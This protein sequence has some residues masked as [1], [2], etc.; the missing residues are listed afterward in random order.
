M[1]IVLNP[2]KPALCREAGDFHVLARMQSVPDSGVRRTP[3]NLVVVIDR[4]GS[5]QGEKLREA[6]RC[7]LDL[8]DRMADTD[9]IGL[10]QYDDEVD[11]LL[12]LQPVGDVRGRLAVAVQSIKS[13]GSTNLHGGWLK[14]GELLAP[15]AGREAVCHVIL[16]SDGQANHGVVDPTAICE[17]VAELAA[18]GI[19]TTTVGVGIDFNESLMTAMARAG[20]GRAHYGERA[21]DLAEPFDAEMGLLTHLQW[22]DVRLSLTHAPAGLRLLNRYEALD[23]GWR[24]PAVA[25]GAESWA[26]F[27]I[28]MREAI[29]MQ[30]HAD[31][32]LALRVEAIDHLGERQVFA[33]QLPLL[34]EVTMDAWRAMPEDVLVRRRLNELRAAEMQLRIRDAAL[35]GDW[36]LASRIV[37]ELE[38]L[39]EDEP[40]VA[41]SLGYVR[42]LLS[43]RDSARMSKEMLYKSDAMM[44]RVASISES[45]FSEGDEAAEASFMRRKTT[46]GRRTE[47]RS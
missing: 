34:P 17:Q 20:G 37:A 47:G 7:V 22:R 38:S 19:T 2:I 46:Q 12:E 39:G 16:L 35:R 9:Q 14:G 32:A 1:N 45:L 13:A 21:I 33:A 6:K 3:L 29:A 28:G 30:E 31:T 41:S 11:V 23:A 18:A 36:R 25:T 8:A 10:V 26:L 5:M 40:W 4:S 27:S 44:A 43:R 42:E 24:L 15:L